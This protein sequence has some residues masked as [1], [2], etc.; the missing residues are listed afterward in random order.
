MY[1][2]ELSDIKITKDRGY[3]YFIDYAHPLACGNSGKVYLHRHI[4]SLTLGRWLVNEEHV[5]HIDANKL[6]N[7]PDNLIV[8][9]PSEHSSIHKPD[10][11]SE[12]ICPICGI[13]FLPKEVTIR[14][15]SNKCAYS[16]NIK[17]KELTKEYLDELIP[18]YSWVELGRLLGYSNN[19]I[20]KR[21]I[22]LGC[23]IPVRRK[24]RVGVKG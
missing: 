15:C 16:N 18:I 11:K 23:K 1:N 9:S 24:C 2:K 6:N 12:L 8:L 17:N 10:T 5:H 13:E 19:G 7:T 3:A 14:F 20:K 4:A 21:A 22:A